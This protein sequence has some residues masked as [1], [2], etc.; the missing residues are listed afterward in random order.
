M[1]E[2]AGSVSVGY[3]FWYGGGEVLHGAIGIGTLVA[4][5]EYIHSLLCA[6]ARLSVKN[7]R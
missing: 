4:F 1:V 3:Y 5:K 2:A 6:A 7:T